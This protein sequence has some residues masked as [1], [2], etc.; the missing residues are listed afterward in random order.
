LIQCITE[1]SAARGSAAETRRRAKPKNAGLSQIAICCPRLSMMAGTVM[2][3]GESAGIFI[4]SDRSVAGGSAITARGNTVER[5]GA[6][7]ASPA[8]DQ[9]RGRAGHV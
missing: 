7:T 1:R 8:R 4:G 9:S 6:A 2:V 3:A 5:H